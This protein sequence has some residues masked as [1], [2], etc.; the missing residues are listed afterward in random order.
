MGFYDNS[1]IVLVSNLFGLEDSSAFLFQKQSLNL[2]VL[3]DRSRFLGIVWKKI[4]HFIAE[5]RKTVFRYFELF[6]AP[7]KKG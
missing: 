1:E 2:D 3:S 5:F 6:I 4:S 7:D